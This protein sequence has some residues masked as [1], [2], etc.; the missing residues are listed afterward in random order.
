M[1]NSAAPLG[2]STAMIT[3]KATAFNGRPLNE[4]LVA[5]FD[6]AGGNIGRRDDNTL[7]LPDPERHISRVHAVI[8]FRS[9]SYVIRDQSTATPV[10]VN[11]NTLGNGREAAIADGDEIR[12]GG[13]VLAVSAQAVSAARSNPV[14]SSNND[15]FAD[16]LAPLPQSF[17]AQ[18]PGTQ[19][20]R[21]HSQSQTDVPAAQ[22]A[23]DDPFAMPAPNSASKSIAPA[24]GT[25]APAIPADFD[26]FA[27]FVPASK[28]AGGLQLPDDIDLGFGSSNGMGANPSFG[29]NE[30]IDAL[31]G[32]SG[33]T[34]SSASGADLLGGPLGVQPDSGLDNSLDPLAAFGVPSAPRSGFKET[35]RNDTPELQGS[36]RLP[37]V[38]SAPP[39]PVPEA[40]RSAQAA[41]KPTQDMVLS[42]ETDAEQMSGAHTMIIG[43]PEQRD[44]AA[45]NSSSPLD[46]LA[47]FGADTSNKAD[48]LVLNA[49]VSSAPSTAASNT[50]TPAPAKALPA[51]AVAAASVKPAAIVTPA[52]QQAAASAPVLLPA[53]RDELLH[54]LLDGAGVPDLDMPGGLTP[55]LMNMI[56]K[57][58]RESTQGTLDLL[59]AR[60]ITKREVRADVTMIV[61]QENNPLKFSPTVEVALSHLLAPQGRGFLT[62]LRA[63]KG[64]YND[65]RSHQIGFM[66]GMQSALKG[67]LA[68]FNPERLEKRLQQKSV[69]DSLLPMNRRAK[70]WDLF[71]EMYGDI[72]KEAEDD[73]HALF[74]KEFLRAYEEQIAKLQKEDK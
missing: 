2:K 72:S 55:Q 71:N 43:A 13:Y 15:P 39:K 28:Q 5:D 46:P 26:P 19:S 27:D 70:L 65:L 61:A 64:A 40:S 10:V 37:E 41:Q 9:G 33:G 58:L 20:P 51:A 21:P 22:F 24:T 30:S 17:N 6:E 47:L 35:Q 66:A 12:I 4:P 25:S 44:A 42:W 23:I 38:K 31:F 16:L 74:G 7:V 8:E 11:R 18:S 73:F 36:M 48:P 14:A 53:Q 69:V 3:I 29:A 45:K 49:A 60:A 32:L 50:N 59:L 57:M 54:A 56:G 52:A 68:R 62:P 63:V 67:V 34:N 1:D